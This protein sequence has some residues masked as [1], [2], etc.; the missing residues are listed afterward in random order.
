MNT[1]LTAKEAKDL[2]TVGREGMLNRILNSIKNTAEKGGNAFEYWTDIKGK[3][4]DFSKEQDTLTELGYTVF[5]NFSEA[6]D[7]YKF[8]INW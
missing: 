3:G 8:L 7:E 4:Q 1:F 5:L 6:N 2:A